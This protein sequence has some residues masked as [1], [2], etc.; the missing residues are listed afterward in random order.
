MPALLHAPGWQPCM[1]E[2]RRERPPRRCT[3]PTP[4]SAR[5]PEATDPVWE[6]RGRPIG[7][8]VG[9]SATRGRGGGAAVAAPLRR[10]ARALG[11]TRASGAAKRRRRPRRH[12]RAHQ[13]TP[14]APTTHAPS[15]W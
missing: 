8:R 3:T 14:R 10:H 12:T 15:P 2:R 6:V 1:I 5:R 11:N 7:R 4:H 13:H 9:D